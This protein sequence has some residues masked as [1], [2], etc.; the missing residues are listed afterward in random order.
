MKALEPTDSITTIGFNI[1]RDNRRAGLFLIGALTAALALPAA[2]EA[3]SFQ[4]L[5]QM[6]GARFGTYASAI[7]SD[8]ST[9]LGYGWVSSSKVQA[10]RW[11]VAGK[12]Q[13]L[14]SPGNSD[15]FGSGALSSDGS[16]IVGE[17]PQPNQFAAFRWTAANGLMTLPFNI[18]AAVSADGSIVAGGDNWWKTSGP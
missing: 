4:R 11:T 16:V 9:I 13:L 1:K 17:N 18:A 7:S 12:Y 15:F 6:P 8:G 5:G 10:Y 14:D 3:A 2:A